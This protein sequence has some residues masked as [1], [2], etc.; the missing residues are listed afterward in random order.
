ML[1]PDA[2]SKL[3]MSQKHQLTPAELKAEGLPEGTVA[4]KDITGHTDV[5]YK[6]VATHVVPQEEWAQYGVDKDIVPKGTILTVNDQGVLHVQYPPSGSTTNLTP[7]AIKDGAFTYITT[8]KFQTGMRDKASMQAIQNFAATLRPPD[9]SRED[10]AWLIQNNGLALHARQAAAGRIATAGAQT[11]VNEGTVNN[12][13]SILRQMM[14]VAASHGPFTDVNDFEQWVGRKTNDPNAVKLK[15]A[16]DTITNEY[17]RVMTGSTTGAPSSDSARS[18]AAERLMT[19]YN[20]GTLDQA[21]G[22]MQQEMRGRSDYYNNVLSQLSGGRY[23]GAP[24]PI[25]PNADL[26][27]AAP[28]KPVAPG[29]TAIPG[30]TPAAAPA[31]TPATANPSVTPPPPTQQNVPAPIKAKLKNGVT[32][33][34]TGN[35]GTVF[36]LSDG[37]TYNAM[38][39]VIQ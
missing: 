29:A 26:S 31:A 27:S 16:I 15:N 35:K 13:I 24:I 20:Q 18:E 12:S 4:E 34:R 22:L 28:A 14:P 33:V 37:R 3:A 38:G 30:M 25:N 17:A 23:G 7:D 19:G 11:A 5:V 36:Q 2:A 39:G 1:G 32:V 10:W 8:G 9:M 21:L 6:P